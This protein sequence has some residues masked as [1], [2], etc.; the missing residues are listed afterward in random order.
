MFVSKQMFAGPGRGTRTQGGVLT[1]FAI[2]NQTQFYTIGVCGDSALQGASPLYIFL[3]SQGEG[4]KFFL[5]LLDLDSFQFNIL[6]MPKRQ[7]GSPTDAQGKLQGIGLRSGDWCR[8]FTLSPVMLSSHHMSVF[9]NLEAHGT[10][11]LGF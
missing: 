2:V 7:L 3:G 9:T 1:D 5:G 4:Q 10:Y 11:F 8:A 6:C